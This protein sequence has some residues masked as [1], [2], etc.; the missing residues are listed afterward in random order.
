MKP[1]NYQRIGVTLVL[2][3]ALRARE[4]ALLNKILQKT[5]IDDKDIRTIANQSLI[6]SY[7]GVQGC[8][9]PPCYSVQ[10]KNTPYSNKVLRQT[11]D[12]IIIIINREVINNLRYSDNTAGITD[13]AEGL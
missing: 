5:N 3:M 7:K 10:I 13:G 12:G 1:V 2:E 11:G 9:F 8:I 4:A 6:I